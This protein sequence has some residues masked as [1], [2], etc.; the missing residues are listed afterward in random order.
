MTSVSKLPDNLLPHGA[1]GL[2]LGEATLMFSGDKLIMSPKGAREHLTVHFGPNSQRLDIHRTTTIADGST[3]HTTFFSISHADLTAM[4]QDIAL[5]LMQTLMGIVHYVDPARMAQQQIGAIIGL[6]PTGAD[7]ATVTH[8]H[9]GKL[10][11][12]AKKISA[13]IWSP[14]FLED[15]YDLED[16]EIFT[17]LSCKNR[18]RPR[19]IGFGFPV[20]DRIGRRRLVWI[21]DHRVVEVLNRAGVL[22]QEAEEKYG[23]FHQPLP[24][25]FQRQW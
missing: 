2:Y 25:D 9:H 6:F 22:L 14:E 1:K 23:T 18:R 19:R 5:P 15:L 24:W 7:I 4:L 3:A 16:G 20:I 13:R 12:D 21:P 8:V 10:V 17:L 11:V